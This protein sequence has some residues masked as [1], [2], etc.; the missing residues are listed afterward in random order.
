[1]D[2]DGARASAPARAPGRAVAG[3]QMTDLVR[4][5]NQRFLTLDAM[6]GIAAL[7]VLTRHFPDLTLP[8]LFQGSYLA[9]DMFFVLSSFVLSHAYG[10]NLA[11]KTGGPAFLL[12][13]AIRLYPLYILG[14]LATVAGYL[15]MWLFWGPWGR[16]RMGISLAAALI[17]LPLPAGLAFNRGVA[18][19]LNQP[20]WS[21]FWEMAANFLFALFNWTVPRLL[22]VVALG[23]VLLAVTFHHYGNLDAGADWDEFLGG[24]G[25]VVYS[26]FLGALLYRF[27]PKWKWRLPAPLLLLVLPLS[28]LLP[29]SWDLAIALVFFPLLVFFGSLTEPGPRL[30]RAFKLLGDISYP[31]YALHFAVMAVMTFAYKAATGHELVTAGVMGTL[32]GMAITAV[33]GH[34]AGRHYDPA[35]RRRLTDAVARLGKARAA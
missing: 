15:L 14:S 7:L 21:L 35:A 34:F 3:R 2:P 19:P 13:R 17:M 28:F 33:I 30:E 11:E 6:R 31:V 26:F 24:G 20:A 23:A 5:E 10:W 8:Q 16:A 1:M 4:R 18:Y 29:A 27:Q 12:K 25:R 32:A 9:V 22:A